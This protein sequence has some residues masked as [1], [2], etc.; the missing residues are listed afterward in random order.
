VWRALTDPD[1][2]APIQRAAVLDVIAAGKAAV[3]MRAAF[4]AGCSVAQRHVIE[5]GPDQAGHPFP[6]ERSV[7]SAQRALEIARSTSDGD[8]LVVLLSGG[9]SSL[10]A[11]PVGDLTLADK[12][13]TVRMLLVAGADIT[14]LNTVRKHLSAIKG[15][16]LAAAAAA[17]T[18]TLAVSDVVGDDLSV[19]GSGP[20]VPDPSTFEMAL[21]VLDRRGGRDTYPP[22]V[23][24]LLQRGL[25]GQIPETPTS[26]DARL[27]RS[28][29][30]VIGGKAAAIAGARAAAEA[31]GYHVHVVDQPVTGEARIAARTH[32]DLVGRVAG[33]LPRPL[34]VLSA[35]ETT[36]CVRGKGRGGRNQEFALALAGS[37]GTLGANVVAASVGTD[38][39]DGPTDAAGAIVDSTTMIR[40]EGAGVG[41]PS[42]YLDDNNSYAFFAALDDLIRTGPTNTNVGDVQIVLVA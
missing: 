17:P 7:K 13:K 27:A 20:T 33:S 10:M 11:L 25:A 28:T 37:I 42:R 31:I 8:L 4:S 39:I 41:T 15:G 14:E 3:P 30:R 32:L 22:S 1:L 2:A 12:Q 24:D 36:V 34:C 19:I 5:I 6:D 35:G 29:A 21:D 23:V 40:S 38:G 18:L 16:Q 26:D 9:A